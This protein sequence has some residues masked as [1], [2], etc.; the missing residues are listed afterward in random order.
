MPLATGICCDNPQRISRCGIADA[1][2][3]QLSVCRTSDDIPQT[4]DQALSAPSTEADYHPG[5]NWKLRYWSIFAGQA[6]SLVGSAL[7]QFVLLW[8][9]TD[10]TGSVSALATAGM[11]AF[12]PQAFV[13]LFG[14]VLADRYS[15]RLL[16]IAA[17]ATSALC[18]LVL[19]GLFVNGRVELWHAYAMMAIRSAMQG[20][21]QPAVAA[22]IAMLVPKD[23]LPRAA[24][25][26]RTIAS[27]TIVAAAPLGALAI[28]FLPLGLA[29]GIDVAT[30]VLGIIPLLI[31]RIPQP[32]VPDGERTSIR[33]EFQDGLRLVWR[34]QGLRHLYALLTVLMLVMMPA[35][36]LIL[37]LAK[38]HF[39]GGP[40]QVATMEAVAGVAIIAGGLIVTLLS[41]KRHTLWVL[42]ASVA[43]SF[44][45]ALTA[46]MPSAFFWAAVAFWALGNGVF[47]VGDAAR[48]ALLQSTIPL[49]QQGRALSLL[50]SVMA[51]AGPI[52]LALAIPIGE[53]IGVRWLFVLMGVVAGCVSLLAFRSSAL[54]ELGRT[55]A[56]GTNGIGHR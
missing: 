39:L 40:V 36:T 3:V 23:F 22:S 16:M 13:G 6:F 35:G 46:L 43:S 17:D 52:G 15:R 14:G 28:S 41:P 45:L 29:L 37:L 11:V 51:F 49:H 26:D 24:G 27:L 56:P 42:W 5:S 54:P 47:V 31:F 1:Q 30:A 50:T 4:S 18:M 8:W 20:F 10:T 38:E 21:Q 2:S 55:G 25:L 32:D 33:S 9:I 12:L 34:N 19:I 44:T 7:T 48:L 53:W